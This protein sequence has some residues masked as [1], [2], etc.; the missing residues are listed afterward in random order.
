MQGLFEK[1]GGAFTPEAVKILAEAFDEAWT[2]LQAK[3]SPSVRPEYAEA[4]RNHLA[5]SVITG[6]RRGE[7]N[8]EILVEDALFYISCQKS[9][10]IQK[11]NNLS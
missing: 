7:C 11:E 8:R 5:K 10:R 2:R 3:D 9:G 4:A 1:F 6:A